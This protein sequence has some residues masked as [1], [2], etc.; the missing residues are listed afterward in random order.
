MT[1]PAFTLPD[2]ASRPLGGSVPWANDELFASRDNLISATE[3][4]FSPATFGARGQVYDGWE[5]RRRREPGHDTAIVRLG[6]PGVVRGIDIDTSHFIGNFPPEGSVEAC[7]LEGYP[8]VTQLLAADWRPLV[9][10]SP[11]AGNAHNRFTI[12]PTDDDAGQLVTHVRL[13][14]YPDGGVA[15]L[16][17]HG[18]PV[19]DP[20][21][22]DRGPLDLAGLENGGLVTDSSNAFFGSPARLIHP[23]PARTMGEGWE[24]ARRRDDGHDWVELKLAKHGIVRLLEL[25]LSHFVGNAPGACEVLGRDTQ[26][27]GEWKV[28]LTRTD[29]LP[30]VRHRFRVTEEFP[31]TELRL[32]VFP[33][34]G[35]A[36]LRAYGVLTTIGRAELGRD[37]FASLPEPFALEVAAI[38]AGCSASE[39]AA[40]IEGRPWTGDNDAIPPALRSLVLGREGVHPGPHAVASHPLTSELR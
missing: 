35:M 6:V 14:I 4:V 21:M 17:I 31:A 2:L 39:A 23:G 3:S 18:E 32:N 29:V 8:D 27:D 37:W 11:L 5:T 22:L 40:L 36:R 25:D 38:E 24:T 1:D 34:G 19:R 33:D 9:A 13:R 20:R 28:V 15:R 16:R 10:R 7:A 26:G 12:E 30:G